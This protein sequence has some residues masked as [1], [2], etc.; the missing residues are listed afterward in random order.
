MLWWGMDE[1]LAEL[2]AHH[3]DS[4]GFEGNPMG[5]FTAEIEDERLGPNQTPANLRLFVGDTR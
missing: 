5:R 3:S 4:A 2:F 1:T